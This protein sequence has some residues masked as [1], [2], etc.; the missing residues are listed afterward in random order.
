MIAF[1]RSGNYKDVLAIGPLDGAK[2]KDIKGYIINESL[3]A[4]KSPYQSFVRPS[5]AKSS[6]VQVKVAIFTTFPDDPFGKPI[7][8][9]DNVD[10][11]KLPVDSVTM[12]P[13]SISSTGKFSIKEIPAFANDN[14]NQIIV[15][16]HI[17]RLNWRDTFKIVDIINTVKCNGKK[18][19]S[20]IKMQYL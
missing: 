19:M 20:D 14:V 10:I 8:L 7:A 11:L 5:K 16:L 3:Y 18:L 4:I 15:P 17:L 13:V 1:S 2:A 9:D 6:A 12:T